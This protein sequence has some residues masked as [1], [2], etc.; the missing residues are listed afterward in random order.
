MPAP[1]SLK[2]ICAATP[3]DLTARALRFWTLKRYP[4]Y[5]VVYRPGTNPLQVIAVLHGKRNLRRILK[6]RE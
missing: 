3:P 6:E 1:F 2:D 4:N 5:I